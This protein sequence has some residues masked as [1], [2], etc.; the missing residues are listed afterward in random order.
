MRYKEFKDSERRSA[1]AQRQ[2]N[3]EVEI[4]PISREYQSGHKGDNQS[5]HSP[6]KR[7]SFIA[8]IEDEPMDEE[9]ES[10]VAWLPQIF[11]GILFVTLMAIVII[12]LKQIKYAFGLFIQWIRD[13]PRSASG[14]IIA[15][16]GIGIALL[17]PTTQFHLA[18]GYTYAEVAGN[19]WE[20]F[21]IAAPIVFVGSMLGCFLGF[22][23]SR[24]FVK[25]MVIRKIHKNLHK[26]QWLRNFDL[27]DE[28]FQEP[29][30][31]L[32]TVALLRLIYLPL[33]L[34][35]YVL[36]VTSVPLP[37]FLLGSCAYIVKASLG[38]LLGT[39]I[40]KVKSSHS[41]NGGLESLIF[42]IEISFSILLTLVISAVAKKVLEDKIKKQQSFREST[43]N[44]ARSEGNPMEH[45]NSGVPRLD[46]RQRPQSLDNAVELRQALEENS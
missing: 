33:G 6:V 16:Y 42:V 31:A 11:C 43:I 24:F 36:G 29:R 28:I 1:E 32:I 30:Q 3:P 4:Q 37:T 25:S 7:S 22:M 41:Q 12:D 40:Y 19:Q 13:N 44:V 45:N 39:Q 18:V 38:A 27:I 35:N 2:D 14:I 34:I 21:L 23:A 26:Y 10:W 15:L 17:L 20:G 46:Q 8:S 9:E 5:I